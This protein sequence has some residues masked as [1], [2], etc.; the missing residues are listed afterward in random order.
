MGSNMKRNYI[1]IF[2]AIIAFIFATTGLWIYWKQTTSGP[3][4]SEYQDARDRTNVIE[5]FRQN[6]WWL[7]AGRD[8]S[9]KY[10]EDM[11]D[12]KTPNKNSRLIGSLKF[13]TLRVGDQLA[14]FSV[15]YMENKN[16]GRLLFLVTDENHR[17]KGYAE[18]LVQ[19]TVRVMKNMGAKRIWLLTRASNER[20]QRLYRKLG[21]Q[22]FLYDPDGFVYFEIII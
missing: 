10:V 12:K 2:L 15:F 1:F 4:I 19:E 8:F 3:I 5:I 18:L 13:R 7:I 17:K 14:A 21:F 9:Q 22:E 6:W 11:L 16:T 20:A